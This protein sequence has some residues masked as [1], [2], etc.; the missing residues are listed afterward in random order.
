MPLRDALARTVPVA[1]GPV[2]VAWL[3]DDRR[4]GVRSQIELLGELD[5]ERTAGLRRARLKQFVL[6]RVL[7]RRLVEELFPDATGW[8]VQ[9][10]VCPRCGER[11]AGVELV[12]VPARASVAYAE[13]L[14]VAAVAPS[15][16]VSRLGIDVERDAHDQERAEELRRLIGASRE[17]VLRRWTRVEA[18]LK[19]DGRGLL[20]D[21]GAVWLRRGGGWIAGGAQSYLVC[22]IDGPQGYLISLAWSAAAEAS[23][24]P[25]ARRL[26]GP[27]GDRWLA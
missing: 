7:L 16:T 17:N 6:G 3:S 12:G 10:G 5:R 22:E 13:G 20:I 2:S 14:V 18:V 24:Q 25:P 8:T 9:P 11:H 23:A 1:A 21:P 26:A 4:I 15:E 27:A 19:A